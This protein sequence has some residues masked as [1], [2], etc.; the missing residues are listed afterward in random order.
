MS[1][2]ALYSALAQLGTY[3]SQ[4][5]AVFFN[6]SDTPAVQG[7]IKALAA[8]AK[9]VGVVLPASKL[10][11]AVRLSEI[12]IGSVGADA[13]TLVLVVLRRSGDVFEALA[14]SVLSSTPDKESAD[15]MAAEL[16]QHTDRPVCIVAFAE[17]DFFGQAWA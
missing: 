9:S 3:Y 2:P 13:D 8:G 12:G 15:A 7:A 14:G 5:A 16:Q 4:D 1:G 6:L 17:A 11:P 10:G